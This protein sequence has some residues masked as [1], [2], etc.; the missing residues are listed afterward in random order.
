V[1]K[2]PVRAAKVRAH[3]E[4]WVGTARRECL[5]P[6]LS[7]GRHHLQHVLAVC[8]AH[9]NVLGGLIHDTRSP[10]STSFVHSRL[11]GS[12]RTTPT[13]R[14]TGHLSGIVKTAPWLCTDAEASSS[15]GKE[16][17]LSVRHPQGEIVSTGFISAGASRRDPSPRR[18]C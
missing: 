16:A 12:R 15:I 7:V 11:L 4:R 9:Y 17:H 3:A 1:V 6:I 10:R 18:G 14:T 2:A 8:V 13:R 5:D